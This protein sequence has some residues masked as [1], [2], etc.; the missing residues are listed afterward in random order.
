MIYRMVVPRIGELN[1][2]RLVKWARAVGATVTPGDLV[3]ELETDKALVEVRAGQ[4]GFL[5]EL[6]CA[7]GDWYPL[8]AV[9][10][11]L[12][13]EPDEPIPSDLDAHPLWATTFEVV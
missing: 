12:T 1:E 6:R 7:E 3:V 2:I 11:V 8:G 5:R 4:A 10:G 9:L 13:S